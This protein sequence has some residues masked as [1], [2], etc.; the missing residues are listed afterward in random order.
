MDQRKSSSTRSRGRAVSGQHFRPQVL[1]QQYPQSGYYPQPPPPVNPQF[2]QEHYY[3]R[4][5]PPMKPS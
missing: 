4:P 1:I 3:T 2:F 5:P